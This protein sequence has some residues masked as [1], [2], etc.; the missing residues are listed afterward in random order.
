MQSVVWPVPCRYHG[1]FYFNIMR[2]EAKLNPAGSFVELNS[3]SSFTLVRDGR[4]ACRRINTT[5]G[6]ENCTRASCRRRE[7]GGS[8]AGLCLACFD[9]H[10]TA[11]ADIGSVVIRVF[12]T[13]DNDA[14]LG[15]GMREEI[16]TDVNPDM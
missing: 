13:G 9:F 12:K 11:G 7:K 5:P 16:V 8:A 1:Y 3:E 14:V 4:E 15:A 10:E 2:F 6:A